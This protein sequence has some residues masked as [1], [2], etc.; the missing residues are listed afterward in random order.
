[1]VFL[2]VEER[3]HLLNRVRGGLELRSP[4]CTSRFGDGFFPPG[5]R[6]QNWFVVGP[7]DVPCF[8]HTDLVQEDVAGDEVVEASWSERRVVGEMRRPVHVLW[9]ELPSCARGCQEDGFASSCAGNCPHLTLLE[10]LIGI[11]PHQILITCADPLVALAKQLVGLVEG[12]VVRDVDRHASKCKI[13]CGE[14]C[15]VG[16]GSVPRH[17]M[18]E[19]SGVVGDPH[20]SPFVFLSVPQELPFG[21]TLFGI[22]QWQ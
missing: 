2:L 10:L 1:M 5:D 20:S 22:P 17:C 15:L 18:L 12:G 11:H 6:G 8:P 7:D 16:I 19:D 21:G 9:R 4:P 14:F 3:V 13:P